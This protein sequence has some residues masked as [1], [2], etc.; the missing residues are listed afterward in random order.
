MKRAFTLIEL[1]VVIAIIAILAAILFPVFAQ[2]KAAAKKTSALSNVKQDALGIIM[3]QGDFDDTF[4]LGAPD[5]WEHYQK[6]DGVITGTSITGWALTTKPYIKNIGILRD[7]SDPLSNPLA[8]DY[9]QRRL[10][11][12]GDAVYISFASNGW[13]NSVA[14]DWQWGMYGVIGMYQNWMNGPKTATS[15]T[16]TNIADTVMLAS[17]YGSTDVWGPDSFIAGVSWW[18]GT[19]FGGLAPDGTRDGKPYTSGS[20]WSGRSGTFNKNN[21]F[22]AVTAVYADKALFA[23]ADGHASAVNP[24]STNPDPAGQPQNNKW[25][26]RR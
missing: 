11:A 12:G 14:P 22:G 26:A 18:D 24:A 20:T 10:Q 23:W 7:P 6:A 15:S 19:G 8:D 16:V 13:M 1:L 17:R 5:D 2:A 9:V 4:P 25:N 3:Y 21:K